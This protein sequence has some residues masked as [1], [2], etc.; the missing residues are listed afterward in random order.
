MPSPIG[1]LSKAI[2]Q[3]WDDCDLSN[4]FTGG[5]WNDEIPRAKTLPYVVF[6]I[7]DGGSIEG[8]SV[9]PGDSGLRRRIQM[10]QV[11]MDIYERGRAAAGALC[12][13]LMDNFN[14]QPLATAND[15]LG[16]LGVRYFND[17]C[18]RQSET[19]YRWVLVFEI[20]YWVYERVRS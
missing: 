7:P 15:E 19:V 17:Y 16:V 11:E 9:N 20:R 3:R 14:D 8:R 6:A 4:T 18:L 5:I 2:M 10:T 1:I 13:K 12:D